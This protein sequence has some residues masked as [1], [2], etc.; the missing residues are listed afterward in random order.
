MPI[1]FPCPHC[2][3]PL[4]I[5]D[6]L[7][8][9]TGRCP[10]CQ[11]TITV[12]AAPTAPDAAPPP[13]PPRAPAAAR[14]PGG[15][16]AGA[17]KA[18]P[19]KKAPP[20]P[21]QAPPKRTPAE[22]KPPAGDA[23]GVQVGP[24][25]RA[26]QDSATPLAAS[27]PPVDA[28]AEAAAV[29]SDRADE[30]PTASVIVDFNCPFC[31]TALHLPAE[32]AGKKSPCPNPECRRIIKVPELTRTDPKD[33]RK[34][35]I[36]RPSLAKVDA[37]PAPEGAWGSTEAR[38]ASGQALFEAGVIQRRQKPRTVVQKL[39]WPVVSG[40]VVLL[41]A[42][43]G[44]WGYS[45][46]VHNREARALAEVEQYA[47]SD[48]CRQ[49][50]GVAGQAELY[51]GV[52]DYYLRTGKPL[53]GSTPGCAVGARDRYGKALA[54]LS[55]GPA[56]SERDATLA[57]LALAVPEL[58]GAGE[59]VQKE[60]RIPWDELQKKLLG[61]TLSAMNSSEGRLDTLRAVAR[62]LLARGQA[63]R[64]LPL[65]GQ[66]FSSPEAEK[67]EAIAAVG[68]EFL[69]A[70]DKERA[71][72]AAD[73]ALALLGD[74]PP[75][76]KPAVV[77]LALA[78]NL[79][80]RLPRV[81]KGNEEK[82]DRAIGEAEGLARQDRWEDAR[83]KAT[84]EQL[85]PEGRFR[86]LVGVAAAAVD[87]KTP[88]A[89]AKVEDALKFLDSNKS[90]SRR[91]E[92]SWVLRR[93][94]ELGRQ[95]GV[96]EERLRVLADANPD[97]ALRG[98]AQLAVFRAQLA[99]RRKEAVEDSAAEQTDG[100]SVARF[101]ALAALARHNTRRDPDW[102]KGVGGWEEP[103]RAFGWLGVV[104]GLQDRSKGE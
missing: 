20:P 34:A 9:K 103:R 38:L 45:W 41:L 94:G 77:A 3:Q 71:G 46:W 67:A 97:P 65:A 85:N 76:V 81:G 80:R 61:P 88:D 82:A 58:G 28:E 89:A 7:A 13:A 30:A 10:R 90:V 24:A 49:K 68:L 84:D 99:A 32:L 51:L 33:W 86:A 73:Q 60:L 69:A 95:A 93:L 79:D 78:L 23:S 31:D 29:F 17:A 102:A 11:Q 26:G 56:N 57:E 63:E 50:A 22:N 72:K 70:G 64:V 66:V 4:S 101:L 12:P 21:P 98:R 53:S 43:G 48:A 100:R 18:A 83:K 5:R 40:T 16:A 59:D 52:G 42:G 62:R 37:G 2:K 44:W 6:E 14:P 25:S 75:T 54:A 36:A 8:G 47:A 39:F 104:L 74:N 87:A 15:P 55:Q 1:K 35:D 96:S 92:Q 91:M 19:A 27:T